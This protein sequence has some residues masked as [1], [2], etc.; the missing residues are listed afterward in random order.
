MDDHCPFCLKFDG[1]AAARADDVRYC[2]ECGA[3]WAPLE[4]D[5]DAPNDSV[6]LP[7]IDPEAPDEADEPP[8]PEPVDP[9]LVSGSPVPTAP[10]LE[11]ATPPPTFR[12]PPPAATAPPEPTTQMDQDA[13]RRF[14]GPVLIGLVFAIALTLAVGQ[15]VSSAMR[16]PTPV[17]VR[18]PA[19]AAPPPAP[20]PRPKAAK[21]APPEL[22]LPSAA[23]SPGRRVEMVEQAI[24]LATRHL[25]HATR[26]EVKARVEGEIA[27]LT[28]TVDSRQTL[29]LVTDAVGDVF[30]IKAVD[31]RGVKVTFRRHEV[32]IGDTLSSL[33]AHY[34]GTTS[35]WERIWRANQ[36][37]APRPDAI[38]VG[39][40]L[41]IPTGDE[42]SQ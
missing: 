34:Y 39:E 7:A 9:F 37:V 40:V 17:V 11:E 25:P 2:P 18:P 27:Y 22:D 4:A 41:L 29:E 33:S 21:P 35:E 13:P 23:D 26:V 1:L 31:A 32:K 8:A 38:V 12:R 30:G 16:P 15:L 24:R 6:R 42:G 10:P 20:R 14:L 5:F 19:A 28:G 36:H 3:D